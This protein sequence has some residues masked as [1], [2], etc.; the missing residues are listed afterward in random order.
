MADINAVIDSLY[1]DTPE[2][3]SVVKRLERLVSVH[4]IL[5]DQGA[6]YSHNVK[7]VEQEICWLLGFKL[8][9]DHA[10]AESSIDPSG[11]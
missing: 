1:P 8:I 11:N 7:V 2:A 6:M 10:S 9:L 3:T 4:R 5:E